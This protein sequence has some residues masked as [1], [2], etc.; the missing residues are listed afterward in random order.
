MRSVGYVSDP[1]YLEHLTGPRHPERPQ[2]LEAIASR[3]AASGLAKDLTPLTAEPAPTEAI[4]A[5]HDADYVARVKRTCEQGSPILDSMDTGVSERSYEIARLAAGA[6]IAAADAVASGACSAAFAAVRPPGHHALRD[7]AMGFCLFNS[8][9]IVA[10]HFQRRHGRAKIFIIDWDVHHGNGTQALFYD[11][12]SVF[13][14][15]I[16]Q[17]P[18]Y[19]GTGSERETGRGAGEG[20]TLNAPIPAGCGDDR[21]REIFDGRVVPAIERFAPDAIVISAGF[22]AHRDDPLGGM[23]V[24]EGGFADLTRTVMAATAGLPA[25]PGIVSL[26]EGGYDLDALAASVESHLGTLVRG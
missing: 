17:W 3:V 26:L 9:A 12:P 18:F 11:D 15:S 14:F 10:R 5:V 23:K 25:R 21:Y 19:P 24:T 2:R 13:Y 4:A 6:G 16:H 22:D 7:T 20:F 8:A 1:R